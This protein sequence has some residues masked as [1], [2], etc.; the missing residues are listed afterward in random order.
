MGVPSLLQRYYWEYQQEQP[1]QERNIEILTPRFHRACNAHAEHGEPKPKSQTRTLLNTTFLKPTVDPLCNLLAHCGL[2]FWNL[3]AAIT[4]LSLRLRTDTSTPKQPSRAGST[5]T[6]QEPG[7]CLDLVRSLFDLAGRREKPEFSK[8]GF[9]VQAWGFLSL[10]AHIVQ[11]FDCK[12][13]VLGL[14]VV[15]DKDQR[16]Y[17][18]NWA[19]DRRARS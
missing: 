17:C 3:T 18:R 14:H 11:S 8:F 15:G 19:R 4:P 9:A 6:P 12:S 7:P 10:R 5:L 1:A 16:A 2:S 13:R